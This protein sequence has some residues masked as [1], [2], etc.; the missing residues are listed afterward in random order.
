MGDNRYS[1]ATTSYNDYQGGYDDAQGYGYMP[2][3]GYEQGYGA[4]QPSGFTR[5]QSSNARRIATSNPISN[6]VQR[7]G[8]AVSGVFAKRA[9]RTADTVSRAVRSPR[10]SVAHHDGGDYLGTG[11]P[12][13]VCG[14]PVEHGQARCPH[15]GAFAKP[16][17]ANVLF[18]IGVAVLAVVVVLLTLAINS[19]KPGEA[20]QPSQEQ[21]PVTAGQDRGA[22]TAAVASAQST[23]DAQATQ[24]TYTRY[25]INNLQNAV[26][27]AQTVL[28]DANA[29][30]EAIAQSA[31]A[32]GAAMGSLAVIA[33]DY[34]WPSYD[35]IMANP[36]S[37]VGQQ[38]VVNGTA[39]YLNYHEEGYTTVVL[40]IAG[41]PAQILYIDYYMNDIGYDPIVGGDFNAK[42]TLVGLADDG[43]PYI[44]AD[45]IETA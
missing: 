35:D 32:V 33:S 22:L 42:G 23:I 10:T 40:A 39:Q 13:R 44:L 24:R 34:P 15:C 26:W 38:I 25:S 14:N 43:V 7:I 37:F 21:N 30:D 27:S 19:C 28:A 8:S 18:W 11:D 41:D 5:H 4:Q 1:R 12:C 3:A 2:D 9:P 36:G 16:L 20:L 17:Y 45:A 6:V 31:Q 29:S